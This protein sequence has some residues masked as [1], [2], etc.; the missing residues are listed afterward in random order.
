[1][2]NLSWDSIGRERAE[3]AIYLYRGIQLVESELNEQSIIGFNQN[4]GREVLVFY[5]PSK[6]NEKANKMKLYSNVNH[7]SKKRLPGLKICFALRKQ[8]GYCVNK[9][10]KILQLFLSKE[11]IYH[12]CWFIEVVALHESCMRWSN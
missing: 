10:E 12:S 7:C 8:L 2:S 1:M 11:L 5:R 3:W 9:S 4:W 6:E